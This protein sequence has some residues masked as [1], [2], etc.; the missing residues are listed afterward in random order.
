MPKM[1]SAVVAY[2]LRPSAIG[3]LSDSIGESVPE[4]RPSAAGIEFVICFVEGRVAPCAT[5]D[6]GF[7]VV[8][9]QWARAGILGAFFAENSELL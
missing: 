6:S 5:I 7:G 8:F 1:A 2:N 9:V 3:P 4:G